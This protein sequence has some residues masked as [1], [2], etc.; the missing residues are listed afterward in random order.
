MYWCLYEVAGTGLNNII[1]YSSPAEHRGEPCRHLT[2]SR[3]SPRCGTVYLASAVPVMVG[4][5]VGATLG[6]TT[7]TAVALLVTVSV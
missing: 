2:T 7:T 4:S 3:T 5:P 6:G 1:I